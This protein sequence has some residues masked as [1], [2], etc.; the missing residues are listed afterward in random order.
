MPSLILSP[1][2]GLPEACAADPAAVA[3]SDE[4]LELMWWV[5]VVADEVLLVVMLLIMAALP[6]PR[7]SA[8]VCSKSMGS[9][10]A[11]NQLMLLHGQ[12][13]HSDTCTVA[14]RDVMF[15]KLMMQSEGFSLQSWSL[16]GR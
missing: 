11:G 14:R 9:N 10:A 1:K 5:V 2:L 15:V 13:Y 6:L 16:S 3:V 8:A 12:C 7:V 4:M